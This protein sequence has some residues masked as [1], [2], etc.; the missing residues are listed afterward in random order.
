VIVRELV[1]ALGFN[2]DEK[3]LGG[4][5]RRIGGLK[6]SLAVVAGA[7]AAGGAAL[8]A[9]A[10]KAANVGDDAAKTG[11]AI[12]LTAEQVQEYRHAASLAGIDSGQLTSAFMRLTKSAGDA[13]KGSATLAQ[14]FADLGVE[15]RGVDGE[16]KD[17]STLFEE[18]ADG[19]AKMPDGTAKAAA[20]MNLFGRSG[21]RMLTLL[22]TGA[23]GIREARQEAR[24]LGA[25]LSND[26]AAAGESFNDT[27]FRLQQLV[28]G[29][30]LQLG[31]ALIPEIDDAGQGLLELVKANRELIRVKMREFI[32]AVV[33]AFKIAAI[34][35][36]RIA[37]GVA[38]I[39]R[40]LGGFERALKL[41]IPLL[42]AFV[43]FKGI[44][45]VA[46]LAK[47]FMLAAS[48]VKAFG[49]QGL[50]A[51]AKILAPIALVVAGIALVILILEDLVAWSEGRDSVFG[52]LFPD[53]AFEDIKKYI[54]W[55]MIALGAII[56]LIALVA[57]GWVIAVVA[58]VGVAAGVFAQ[59][60]DDMVDWTAG[61]IGKVAAFFAAMG[62]SIKAVFMG[63]VDAI[64]SAINNV[65]GKVNKVVGGAR[66]LLN[67]LTGVNIGSGEALAGAQVGGGAAG[68]G[69]DAGRRAAQVQNNRSAT[70]S[71]GKVE[72]QVQGSSGMG[73]EEMSRATE[74]GVRRAMSRQLAN[75][76]A[77]FDGGGY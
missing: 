56:G 66:S 43:A 44:A 23:D 19:I 46:A 73:P 33:K 14:T 22:N 10:Q 35:A 5:E 64:T 65:S 54:G 26:A 24:D 55:I 34:W 15:L 75:A 30:A 40:A 29:L 42:L 25:V 59:F 57:G 20:A 6:K 49:V 68:P 27:F 53:V 58:A 63:V 71:I 67:K 60:Y 2:V 32:Q 61:A 16:L 51:W 1:T 47:S 48:A 77:A 3:A 50:L 12:G 18:V 9:L 70:S 72:V 7:A 62:D 41:A 13:D 74:E 4:Y 8:F 39:T 52:G 69:V 31:S 45:G 76:G 38:V 36:K 17:S 28:G 11:V 21:G 37:E